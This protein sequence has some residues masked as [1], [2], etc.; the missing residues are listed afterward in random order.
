MGIFLST[1]GTFI[2]W[3]CIIS[4]RLKVHISSLFPDHF[5][6]CLRCKQGCKGELSNVNGEFVDKLMPLMYHYLQIAYYKGAHND[7]FCSMYT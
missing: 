1:V 5:T 7:V 4:K 2:D 6:Y 3:S